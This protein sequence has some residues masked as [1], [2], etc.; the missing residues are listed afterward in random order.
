MGAG[1]RNQQGSQQGQEITKLKIAGDWQSGH[2][3]HPV[4]LQHPLLMRGEDGLNVRGSK[5][6]LIF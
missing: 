4:L 6:T 1:G 5:T 2:K 3:N